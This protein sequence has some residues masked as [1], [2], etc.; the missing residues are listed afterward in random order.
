[1]YPVT[2]R[3][4]NT[5]V[6]GEKKRARHPVRRR[7]SKE[8]RYLHTWRVHRA[9]G[10]LP[11]PCPTLMHFAPPRTRMSHRHSYITGFV[12]PALHAHLVAS[13]EG[14]TAVVTRWRI[15]IPR[16]HHGWEGSGEQEERDRHPGQRRTRK[17]TDTQTGGEQEKRTQHPDQW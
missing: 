3:E 1:M 11:G 15:R 10:E 17:E 4:P 7:S 5:Q 14:S 6:G 2:Q 12:R 8:R 9:E 16:C 13:G